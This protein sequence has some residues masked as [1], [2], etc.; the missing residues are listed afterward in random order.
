MNRIGL[1]DGLI[2]N[3]ELRRKEALSE[4]KGRSN[5]LAERISRKRLFHMSLEI[6]PHNSAVPRVFLNSSERSWFF[7]STISII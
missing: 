5:Y 6:G 1:L 2:Y 4:T 7:K 3:M